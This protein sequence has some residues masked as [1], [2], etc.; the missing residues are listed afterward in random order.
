M[1]IRAFSNQCLEAD[2]FQELA[3]Q[4]SKEKALTL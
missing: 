2:K 1:E 3:T 4:P